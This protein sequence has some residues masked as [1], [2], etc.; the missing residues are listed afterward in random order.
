MF[1]PF[2][3]K[4]YMNEHDFILWFHGFLEISNAKTLNEKQLQIVKDHL[5][6]LFTKV[7]PDRSLIEKLQDQMLLPTNAPQPA[8]VPYYPPQWWLNNPP[9]TGDPI[10]IDNP[11]KVTCSTAQPGGTTVATSSEP[12]TPKFIC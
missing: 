3:N 6:L 4:H 5:A 9:S 8:T 7:T 12:P 11:Y 2:M 1:P 10:W